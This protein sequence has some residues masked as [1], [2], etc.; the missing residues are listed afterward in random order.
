VVKFQSQIFAADA[1]GNLFAT[2]WNQEEVKIF[3]PLNAN[4]LQQTMF[5]PET[6]LGL[7]LKKY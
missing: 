1:C 6:Q 5:T 4:S 2:H 3:K 7:L